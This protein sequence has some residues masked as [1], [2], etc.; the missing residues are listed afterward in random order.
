MTPATQPMNSTNGTDGQSQ[1]KI[2]ET[3]LNLAVAE[4]E[5]MRE[6]I[7]LQAT[8]MGPILEALLHDAHGQIRWGLNE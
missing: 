3:D 2:M 6:Q 1:L 8:E 7:H 5:K 4:S